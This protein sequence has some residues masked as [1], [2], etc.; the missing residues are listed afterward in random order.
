MI[1]SYIYL[2]DRLQNTQ[3][4]HLLIVNGY[5]IFTGYDTFISVALLWCICF[6][7]ICKSICLFRHICQLWI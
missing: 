7:P 4:T 2:Y 6:S 5:C 3:V 1:I